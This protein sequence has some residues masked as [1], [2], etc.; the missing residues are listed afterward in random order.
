MVVIYLDHNA[1]S[2]PHPR[3]LE[4]ALPFLTEHWGNPSSSH[5]LSRKPVEAVERAR[6]RLAAWAGCLGKEVVFTGSATEANHLALRGLRRPGRPL[7]S[8]IEH[9]SVLAPALALGGAVVAVDRQGRLDLDALEQLLSEPTSLVSVMAANNETGVLQDL[10]AV[11]E[12][13][14]AADSLLHVD[15][16]QLVGRLTAPGSWDLL[17]VTGHKAGGFKG[18]GALCVREGIDIH[19]QSLGGGQER[20]RRS[21]TINPAPLVSLGVVATLAHGPEIG[22][23]RDRLEAACVALG[24][25][26]NSGGAPRLPN[27]CNVRFQGVPSELVV[28][29][30]DL[31]GF[32]LSAGSACHS[33]AATASAVLQAMG[34]TTADALRLSLGW[35]TTEEDIDAAIDALRRVLGRIRAQEVA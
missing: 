24:G 10:D 15:A 19:A 5:S 7:V 33:G 35:S 1:T 34:I 22:G 30:M 16:A 28:M 8:A 27:T 13:V 4:E 9:P 6:R 21:G 3:V 29:G 20:G 32:C 18:G 12:R 26:V 2:P 31:E 25:S 11:A 17:T 14:H 23:M